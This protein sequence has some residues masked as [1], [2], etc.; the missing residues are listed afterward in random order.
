MYWTEI[1]L[2]LEISNSDKCTLAKLMKY[3]W[4]WKKYFRKYFL[5]P[6]TSTDSQ[7][8]PYIWQYSDID[9]NVNSIVVK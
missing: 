7:I 3:Q 8:W 5:I 1:N 9:W 6:I 2:L 4:N